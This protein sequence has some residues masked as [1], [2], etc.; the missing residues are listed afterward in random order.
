MGLRN[1]A[2]TSL[3]R[4]DTA[5]QELAK[6]VSVDE[7]KKL[8]DK[9]EALRVYHKQIEGGLE[10]QNLCA[11]IKIR[12]E[13]RA[14]EILAE[15]TVK[16]G[17]RHKFQDGTCERKSTLPEGITKKQSSRWQAVARVPEPAFEAHIE[18]AKADRQ[19]LTTAGV[20]RLGRD[21]KDKERRDSQRRK[22]QR[23][24]RRTRGE[25]EKLWQIIQGDCL[26]ELAKLNADSARLVFADP[27]YNI[28]VDYGE[29]ARADALPA[30][31]YLA[32]CEEWMQACVRV[33]TPDG[34]LWVMICDEWADHF[35]VILRRVGVQ[36]RSWIKWYET[37]GVN[38]HN[39]F[40]RCSRHIFYCVRAPKRFVFNVDA[41]TRSSDRQTK[42]QDKR[43]NP[44]GKLW[45]NVWQIPRLVGNAAERV[46]DVPTQVP[47]AIMR[48]IVGCASDPGDLVVDPFNGGG[49]T[50]VAAIEGRRRYIGI[51]KNQRYC[52]IS[53]KRLLA[54]GR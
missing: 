40:N 34:S 3:A 35:G 26:K 16:G 10:I 6:V 15:T 13:R 39:N 33:L 11:E 43:A 20:L 44:A 38:C 42:Y 14:G 22:Q 17:A 51:E 49:S 45:D 19:E 46:P 50:G 9:A 1:E 27:P 5:R 30:D 32:W 36:R 48:A 37:F 24:M 47:L 25:D 28:G 8:R 18:S 29:G 12:A 31:D 21:L 53:E 2:I 7:A 23:T 41:V 54:Q 4:I 52:E